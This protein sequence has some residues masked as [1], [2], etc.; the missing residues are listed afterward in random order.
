MKTE[1][2]ENQQD[3]IKL[4]EDI[5]E[6]L[7]KEKE[8]SEDP[9]SSDEDNSDDSNNSDDFDNGDTPKQQEENVEKKE[10]KIDIPDFM[11]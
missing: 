6:D 1:I 7:K 10:K 11:K 2:E 4:E 9:E 8:N 3:I 5:V